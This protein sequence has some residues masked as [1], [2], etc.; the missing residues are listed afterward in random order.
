VESSGESEKK[1]HTVR[2]ARLYRKEG[3]GGL[4]ALRLGALELDVQAEVSVAPTESG[5]RTMNWHDRI[6]VDPKVLV[7]KPV[8]DS[9]LARERSSKVRENLRAAPP[10]QTIT[11]RYRMT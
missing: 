8:I 4:Y 3:E 2:L 7:G 6:T 11:G 10:Q 9:G 1:T 5:R